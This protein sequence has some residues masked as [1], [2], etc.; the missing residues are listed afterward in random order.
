MARP[1]SDVKKD[2]RI[3]L[4]VLPELKSSLEKLAAIDD[5]SVNSLVEKV[6]SAYVDNRAEEITEY[7]SALRK[8]REKSQRK[9]KGGDVNE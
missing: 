2:S 5:V 6:L 7:D 9:L 4:A 1:V 3:N 8:I